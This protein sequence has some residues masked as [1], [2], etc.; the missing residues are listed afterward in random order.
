MLHKNQNENCWLPG[1]PSSR[2]LFDAWCRWVVKNLA[3]QLPISQ[4]FLCLWLLSC[5]SDFWTWGEGWVADRCTERQLLLACLQHS[6]QFYF[7]LTEKEP[8]I[9]Q[10]DFPNGNLQFSYRNC[11]VSEKGI[12]HQRI[13]LMENFPTSFINTLDIVLSFL[14]FVYQCLATKANFQPGFS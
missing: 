1:C 3:G 13:I 10:L 2:D 12:F 14:L 6:R 7:L 11:W 4:A 5:V 9:L 8:R